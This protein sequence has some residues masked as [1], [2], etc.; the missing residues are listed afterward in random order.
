MPPVSGALWQG[1]RDCFEFGPVCIQRLPRVLQKNAN[2]DR[3]DSKP[4][5][6][7]KAK[8]DAEKSISKGR[9][10]YLKRLAKYLDRQS[11]DCLY[12]NIYAP[13]QSGECS[14][15]EFHHIRSAQLLEHISI[16][17][18]RYLEDVLR[19]MK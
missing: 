15:D 1:V 8:S 19:L 5:D 3:H 11:E 4:S 2:T 17:I 16:K 12:L 18:R 14:G 6:G 9:L 7:N 10:E 13:F